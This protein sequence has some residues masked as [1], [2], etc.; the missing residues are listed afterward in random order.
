MPLI[1]LAFQLAKNKYDIHEPATTGIT[2]PLQAPDL[3]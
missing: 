1:Y 2:D 3:G